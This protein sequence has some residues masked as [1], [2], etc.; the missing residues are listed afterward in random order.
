MIST[1]SLLLALALLLVVGVVVLRPL[2]SSS[3]EEATF[4]HAAAP[5]TMRQALEAQK[6]ALLE[7]IR[8]LDFD[9]ETGKVPEQKYRQ[10][11][12][13]L[14]AE[15]AAILRELDTLAPAANGAG[16]EDQEMAGEGLAAGDAI[17]AAVSR[18]RK[19]AD[20]AEAPSAPAQPDE[21]AEAEIE[22]AIARLRGR[23]DGN[24]AQKIDGGPAPDA[25]RTAGK[26]SRFCPQCGEPHDPD[27]KF[28]A[29]CGRRLD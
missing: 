15:A 20:K 3:P 16:Q 29:Y 11:R 28:C 22:A 9:H 6:D 12:E 21:D 19:D 4:A 25:S 1:G 26:R 2:L 10:R 27:D 5:V 17:E 7:Q 14:A 18:L 8:D 24:G 13:E 23:P